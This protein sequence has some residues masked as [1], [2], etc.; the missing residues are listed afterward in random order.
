MII[1]Y[2]KTFERLLSK[3]NLPLDLSF[4]FPIP[5]ELQKKIDDEI[6]ITQDEIT[7]KFLGTIYI[8]NSIKLSSIEDF[9][10]H[11][12]VSNYIS[13]ENDRNSFRLAIK[14][15]LLLARKFQTKHLDKIRL[16]LSFQTPELGQQFANA[17]KLN[18]EEDK[19]FISDR[20]S[21]YKKRPE[22][23]VIEIDNN[24]ELFTAIM[25]IDV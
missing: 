18:E 17:N 21:F 23:N 20:L 10:N 12:H 1:K 25:T 5:L 2:N 14:T 13:P 16:W 11:F 9:N 3:Y 19:H 7:V 24:K 22:D 15:L 8:D 4:S 6:I